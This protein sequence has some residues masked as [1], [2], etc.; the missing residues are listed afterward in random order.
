MC[1]CM[2]TI[3]RLNV[4]YVKDLFTSFQL[5]WGGGGGGG[6]RGTGPPGLSVTPSWFILKWKG[7][8][9]PKVV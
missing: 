2:V 6:R 8:I 7:P 1:N 4:K 9:D 5:E 3:A